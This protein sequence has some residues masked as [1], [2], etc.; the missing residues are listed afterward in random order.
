MLFRSPDDESLQ[1][2]EVERKPPTEF[3]DAYRAKNPTISYDQMAAKIGI[4]RDSLFKIKEEKAWVREYAYEAVAQ[5]LGCRPENL[6]PRRIIKTP[7]RG[8]SK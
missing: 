1:L 4:S 3:F 6:H 5:T 8:R 2:S 7:R